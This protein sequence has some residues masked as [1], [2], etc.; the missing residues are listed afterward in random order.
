MVI[1]FSKAIEF[2]FSI[3]SDGTD[4]R[5]RL[6]GES[7]HQVGNTRFDNPPFFI[8]QFINGVTENLNMITAD[9]GGKG[10][11]RTENIGG[12]QTAAQPGF[13]NSQIDAGTGKVIKRQ[14]SG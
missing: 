6:S 7:G 12:I 8:G 2:G 5:H 13:D 14:R 10:Q 4:D 1:V 9:I 3:L 11:K